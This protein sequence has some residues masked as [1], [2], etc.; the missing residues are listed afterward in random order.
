MRRIQAGIDRYWTGTDRDPLVVNHVSGSD[1]TRSTTIHEPAPTMVAGGLHASLLVPVEGRDGKKPQPVT[2]PLRTQTTRNETGL[3]SPFIA[4]LRGGSSDARPVT[5]PLAT[6]TASGT[7][8]GLVTSK[9]PNIE[10][11]RFRMLTPNEIKEAMAFPNSYRILGTKR[12]QVRMAGN[13]VTPPAAR[14]LVSAVATSL[15]GA[16]A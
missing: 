16:A 9:K 11:C 2:D 3:L 5:K 12:D 8:H 15:N 7:H 13:A 4:E 14:D 1:H 10:D 6:V